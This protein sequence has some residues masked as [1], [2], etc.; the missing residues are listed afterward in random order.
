M[1]RGDDSIMRLNAIRKDQHLHYGLPP[2]DGYQT[3]YHHIG[4]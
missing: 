2:T 1:I 4:T 3:K